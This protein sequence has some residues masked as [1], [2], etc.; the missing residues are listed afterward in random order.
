[1]ALNKTEE[2]RVIV[3]TD[4]VLQVVRTDIIEDDG[5]EIARNDERWVIK[6]GEDFSAEVQLVQDIA[7]AVHTGAAVSAY[8]LDN[9]PYTP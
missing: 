1:M 2:Y 5:L 4:L 7:G 3:M 6:P 9:P 8:L